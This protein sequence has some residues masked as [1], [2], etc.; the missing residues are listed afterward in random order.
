MIQI[1]LEIDPLFGFVSKEKILEYNSQIVSGHR[2][3]YNKTG[4]GNEYLGWVEMPSRYTVE[5]L[6]HIQKLAQEFRQKSELIVI[7][8]AEEA[9]LG[10]RAVLEALSHLPVEE[11][12]D[13]K[14][15]EMLFVG[16]GFSASA[17]ADLVKKLTAID[18][19]VV[20]IAKTQLTAGN[21][22]VFQPVLTCL[23]QK[24][25][26]DE[27]VNRLVLFCKSGEEI[28]GM[29]ASEIKPK[30]LPFPDDISGHFAALSMSGLFLMALACI[31][32]IDLIA[33]AKKV[34]AASRAVNK[35][36]GNPMA[37]YAAARQAVFAIGKTTELFVV[38]EPRLLLFAEWCKQL[39][40]QAEPIQRQ[41][42]KTATS[43][44]DASVIQG[45]TE[46]AEV[47]A[48]FFTTLELNRSVQA[49][50][51]LQ[52]GTN[53]QPGKTGHEALHQNQLPGIR[54][55]IPE[56]S[57]DIMGQLIY[58]FEMAHVVGAYLSGRNPFIRQEH[59]NSSNVV[60]G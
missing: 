44:P 48:C 58:F 45:T 25:A 21:E 28:P 42:I 33:G 8:S 57:P 19:S 43:I 52:A 34:E 35:I 59:F 49:N 22:P 18:F 46:T 26:T 50:A 60:Q 27:W 17:T 55:H 1:K 3:I 23:S 37:L 15:P 31:P 30:F 5:E 41:K 11:N 47:N 20:V 24:Y 13:I 2:K 9:V 16:P 40:Q 54:M 29:P 14:A 38:T 12:V 56:I 10:A 36:Y 7:F 6:E 39:H 4:V 51:A 53:H 32:V